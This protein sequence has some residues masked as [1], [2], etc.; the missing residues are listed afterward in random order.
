M[1]H[2][3]SIPVAL[4]SAG[5]YRCKGAWV[6]PPEAEEA[7]QSH[8]PDPSVTLEKVF[9][10]R[11]AFDALPHGMDWLLVVLPGL[12]P[13]GGYMA[14][15]R[16]GPKTNMI[17]LDH[18]S[19]G[20]RYV[21]DDVVASAEPLPFPAMGGR[22]PDVHVSMFW[23]LS[24]GLLTGMAHDAGGWLAD[25]SER[26]A[27]VPETGTWVYFAEAPPESFV[28]SVREH[29]V[30]WYS[31]WKTRYIG[32]NWSVDPSRHHD[33]A[34]QWALMCAAHASGEAR[35]RM[36][37]THLR[38]YP[39]DGRSWAALAEAYHFVGRSARALF[40]ARKASALSPAWVYPQSL[41]ML[42][43][44]A[45]GRLDESA[46]RCRM[47]LAESPRDLVALAYL[48]YSLYRLN[49]TEYLF[50]VAKTLAALAPPMPSPFLDLGLLQ[51]RRGNREEALHCFEYAVRL[52]PEHP[53]ALNNYGFLLA[54]LGDLEKALI[55]CQRAC[56]LE[57]SA[58]HLDSLG[59]VYM[60]MGDL[61][62]AQ[63][64]IGRAMALD[65][66]H[67]ES[68]EHWAE[69]ERMVEGD[70]PDHEG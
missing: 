12:Y 59:F 46:A 43:L 37:R 56:E 20:S 25:L 35:I 63:E 9:R 51:Y 18:R 3:F 24:K 11:L 53:L 49:E 50:E 61:K 19:V 34:S 30:A 7:M 32:P 45:M 62:K 65:E 66:H 6:I 28:A 60:K 58:N 10:W 42:I 1:S 27:P 68:R 13:I 5:P 67:V 39:G 14:R 26:M 36:L 70:R 54:E 55:F 47:I 57:E 29:N 8:H 40:S 52:D 4:T 64:L 33:P 21:A 16:G 69:L 31:S 22:S 41:A 44:I 23:V 17:L 48:V 2:L 15:A 38:R